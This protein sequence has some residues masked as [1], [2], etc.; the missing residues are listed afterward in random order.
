MALPKLLDSRA[1][2]RFTQA[3]VDALGGEIND[4]IGAMDINGGGQSKARMT[5]DF[6]HGDNIGRARR[7]QSRRHLEANRALRVACRLVFLICD[8]S[9]KVKKNLK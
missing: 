7:T 4:P 9:S 2:P 1:R 8:N 3:S 6:G 5:S